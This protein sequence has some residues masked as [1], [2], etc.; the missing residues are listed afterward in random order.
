MNEE[1]LKQCYRMFAMLG[2]LMNG[3][4]H[5]HEIPGLAC[6]MADAMLEESK[7]KDEGIKAVVKRVRKNVEKS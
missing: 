2:Y 7:P 4:Y 3:D 6:A 5:P 1:D